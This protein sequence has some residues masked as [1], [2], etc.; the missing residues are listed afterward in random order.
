MDKKALNEFMENKIILKAPL[1]HRKETNIDKF[2]NG[3]VLT[4]FLIDYRKKQKES[5]YL[6]NFDLDDKF[7]EKYNMYWP[8]A[9]KINLS[10]NKI[11]NINALI[12]KFPKARNI[13][14]GNPDSI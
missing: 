7:T 14:L 12:T 2:V 6:T 10:N 1:S 3:L 5:I 8:E 11:N 13:V 9:S 4:S